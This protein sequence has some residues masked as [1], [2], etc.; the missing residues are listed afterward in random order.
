MKSK[1]KQNFYIN[2]EMIAAID[3]ERDCRPTLTT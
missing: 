1:E 2:F 3:F